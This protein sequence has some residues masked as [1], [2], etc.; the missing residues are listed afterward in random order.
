MVRI[1]QGLLTRESTHRAAARSAVFLFG[2]SAA[3]SSL[4]VIVVVNSILHSYTYSNDTAFHSR[5][6]LVVWGQPGAFC[7]SPLSLQ[8]PSS[9]DAFSPRCWPCRLYVQPLAP[10]LTSIDE[11]CRS[12]VL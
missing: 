2:A 1:N 11:F 9:A 8:Q 12:F 7:A 5:C 4:V 10:L 3:I 6:R